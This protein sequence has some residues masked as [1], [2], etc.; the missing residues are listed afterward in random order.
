MPDDKKIIEPINAGFDEVAKAMVTPAASLSNQSKALTTVSGQRPATP[1][2]GVLDL[3]IEVERVVGGIEMGV[4]ENGIPYLTQ[5]GLAEM[6]GA[7]RRSIQ[8]ITE[9]WQEAQATEVWRGRMIYF[10]D[11]LSKS[12]FDDPRLFIEITKDGSPHYAYPDMVCM[13]MVEYFAFEAQRTNDTAVTNFRNLAR[14]GLQ[15]FIYDALGYV[16]EDPWKLF[17]ARV[18]L[19]K[20]SV[21]IGYF[22]VFKESTGLVVD[23]INAGL[24]V[25]QHTV[26][27]GS[28]GTTWGPYWTKNGLAARYGERIEYLHYYPSEY[29]QSA[30]N[31]QKAWAYPD[32]ALAEFRHWFRVTYLQTKYPA[33]IL[34]KANILA[35]GADSARQLAAM[36]D[37]K[38]IEG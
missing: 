24:P 17:T 38:A 27:D 25:N 37:P 26:P 5:R 2:Q 1:K 11:Y 33:Y 28:V 23:L 36:Y 7:A 29:P 4:L 22:S 15:K 16:P 35:G 14:Y 9:E 21:P 18:S 8:E 32:Q 10:R 20:D 34:K 13:A 19:L 12:G 31:P 30:S 6:A 3:G